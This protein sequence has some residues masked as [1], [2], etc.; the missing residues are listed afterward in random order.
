MMCTKCTCD[1]NSILQRRK[2]SDRADN[3]VHPIQ[4]SDCMDVDDDEI[5]AEQPLINPGSCK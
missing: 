3:L 2:G 4:T 5:T 1:G